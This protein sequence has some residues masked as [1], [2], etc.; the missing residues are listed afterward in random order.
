VSH[1]DGSAGEILMINQIEDV[2]PFYDRLPV[3]ADHL[4]LEP[5]QTGFPLAPIQEPLGEVKSPSASVKLTVQLQSGAF[6]TIRWDKFIAA[7]VID[8]PNGRSLLG[9]SEMTR[10]ML[11]CESTGLTNVPSSTFNRIVHFLAKQ[12][13]FDSAQEW[14]ARLPQWDRT[15]R[16]ERF[17]PDCLGTPSTAYEAAVSRYMWTALAARILEPGCKADMMPVLVGPEGIQKSEVLKLIAPDDGYHADVCLTDRPA[18]LAQT[19]F[20]RSV[21]VWEELQGIK[22]RC[23]YDRVKT[24]LT[25]QYLEVRSQE[26]RLGMDRYPCRYLVFGTST[27]KGFL[28][29]RPEYRRFLPFDVQLIHLARVADDKLQLWAEALHIVLERMAT[30][31]PAIDFEDAERLA[32]NEH[33]KY[34]RQ[35]RW[36]DNPQLDQWLKCRVR[37]FSTGEALDAIGLGSRATQADRIEMANS[38]RQLGYVERRTRVTGLEHNRKRW[39]KPQPP[40]DRNARPVIR[41]VIR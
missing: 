1:R 13:P 20:G 19:I 26:K 17:L 33:E 15:K 11:C 8:T 14:L 34:H 32:K 7:E 41:P 28:R 12:N 39:H 3:T 5:E 29:G 30:G 22:G 6:G 25:R 37:R 2:G 36:V 18:E 40:S 38:L 35:A 24:F 31:E 27:T 10:L 16:V 9:A 23:D 4:S 21:L